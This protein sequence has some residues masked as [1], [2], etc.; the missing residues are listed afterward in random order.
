MKK[1]LVFL[2][3]AA[4]AVP[5]SAQVFIG[6]SLGFNYLDNVSDT[7]YSAAISQEITQVNA[8]VVF[9][10]TIGYRINDKWS[11]GLDLNVAWQKSDKRSELGAPAGNDTQTR[12]AANR[13]LLLAI[14]PF[15][16]YNVFKIHKFG[17]D[18]KLSGSIGNTKTT[19]D[20][21]TQVA[22]RTGTY[23]L[24]QKDA[25]REL[26]YG[27]NLSPVLTFDITDHLSLETGIGVAGIGWE[28][29]KLTIEDSSDS[30][31]GEP[32]KLST[33]ETYNTFTF[34]LNNLTAV[35][36]GCIYTF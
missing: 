32:D 16:R 14:S 9:S 4:L 3:T 24:T 15:A 33:S 36:F 7:P 20:S 8:R 1:L 5:A 28:G 25:Q 11:A 10:P 26:N 31:G 6:G 12:T 34:G 21:E 17:I 29:R 2:A 22:A 27:I 19:T 30:R 23:T 18:L 35:S 13:R